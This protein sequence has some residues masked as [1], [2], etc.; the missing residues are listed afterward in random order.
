MGEECG[1][2][3]TVEKR[4]KISDEKDHWSVRHLH[5]KVLLKYT[6]TIC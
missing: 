3:R 5:G 6:F 1:T 4:I 2:Q